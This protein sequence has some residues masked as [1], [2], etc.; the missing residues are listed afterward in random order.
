MHSYC[1]SAQVFYSN[2]RNKDCNVMIDGENSYDE[3]VK[4][5]LST[6]GNIHKLATSQG[7]DYIAGCFLDHLYSKKYF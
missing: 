3:P 7:D 1:Y 6:Y 2:G 4:N 5:D